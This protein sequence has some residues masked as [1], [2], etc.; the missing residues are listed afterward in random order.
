M[1]AMIDRIRQETA[2]ISLYPQ[3]ENVEECASCNVLASLRFFGGP[4]S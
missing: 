3:A 1:V 2:I 4:P